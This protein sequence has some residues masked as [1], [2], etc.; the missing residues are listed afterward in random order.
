MVNSSGIIYLNCGTKML[1]RLL[2]SI[3]SLRKYYNGNISIIQI[4]DDSLEV[5][6][7]IADHFN[8]NIINIKQELN[9]RHSYWFEK[10]RLHKYTIYDNNIF[11]DSDT[12]VLQSIDDVFPMIEQ[13]DFVV[14]QF[15]HW[16]T[17]NHRIRKRLSHWKHIE[18]DLFNSAI[19]SK[20]PSVNV[21]VYGFKKDSTFML[22]WFDVTIQNPKAPLPEESTCHLLLNK[23]PSKIIDSSYNYSCKHETKPI[24]SAK[25]IHY[26][27]RK[28]CRKNKI[29]GNYLYNSI[30]WINTFNTIFDLNMCNVKSWYNHCKDRMLI[31]Y[32]SRYR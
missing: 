28:H 8:C 13:Y 21:G 29:T 31:N 5:L 17:K 24:E 19:D 2:V 23:Y 18:P 10:S 6:N 32:A 25:V 27:G 11:L 7:L 30:Y 4:G 9:I 16:T 14:P 15:A 20:M 26:H 3:F 22:N 12:L 1:P